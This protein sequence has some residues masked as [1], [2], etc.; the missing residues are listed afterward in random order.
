[1]HGQAIHIQPQGGNGLDSRNK[2][3]G[4]LWQ[5]HREALA[6]LQPWMEILPY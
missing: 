4:L 5:N 1:M 2:N 6:F 3:G